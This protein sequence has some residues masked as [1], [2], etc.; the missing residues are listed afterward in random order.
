MNIQTELN[1]DE[2]YGYGRLDPNF[3]GLREIPF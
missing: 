3:E 2:N 1:G